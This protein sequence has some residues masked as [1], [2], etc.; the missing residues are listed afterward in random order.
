[1]VEEGA[2]IDR[3]AADTDTRRDA[4]PKI[5]HLRGCFIS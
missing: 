2:A 3:I 1:M 4:D 5:L